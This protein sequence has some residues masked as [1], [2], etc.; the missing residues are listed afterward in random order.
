MNLLHAIAGVTSIYADA[1]D[2]GKTVINELADKSVKAEIAANP[3][4][5]AIAA[6]ISADW[7]TVENDVTGIKKS[8]FFTFFSRVSSLLSAA[9]LMERDVLAEEHDPAVAQ[10]LTTMPAT[11]AALSTISAKWVKLQ[12]DLSAFS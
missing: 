6:K 4:I 5:S 11:L 8:S 12:A 10:A 7:R 3:A 1:T 2:L 9:K